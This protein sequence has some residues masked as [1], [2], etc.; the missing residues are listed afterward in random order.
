MSS[1]SRP[2]DAESRARV[3]SALENWPAR[4]SKRTLA[5]LSAQENPRDLELLGRTLARSGRLAPAAEEFL[6]ACRASRRHAPRA[7]A[8]YAIFHRNGAE[9][10]EFLR[11]VRTFLAAPGPVPWPVLMDILRRLW[12]RHPREMYRLMP[13]WLTH[14][15]PNHRWAA[16][17]GL[18]IPAAKDPRAALKVI[19][20]LRGERSG[21]VRRML[22]HVLGQ[23]IYP[24]HPEFAFEEMARWLG[25]GAA[26]ASAVARQAERQMALWFR[27]GLGNERQRRRILRV[28][29]EYEEHRAAAVRAHARRVSRLLGS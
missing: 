25:D 11:E 12:A 1:N 5:G 9:P 24:R 29:E 4:S 6:A 15:D 13:G 18:E 7:V 20:L 26:S 16:L 3:L 14:R 21:R 8:L 2:P 28:A 10:R 19:R 17:H 27:Q 23:G 22:G